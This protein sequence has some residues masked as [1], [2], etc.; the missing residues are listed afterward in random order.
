M[1]L[2]LDD[3][4]AAIA[5]APGAAGL[6]VVR[7][8]GRD[9]LAVADRVFR[10]RS[11]LESVAS[12]TLHH[13]W[14]MDGE[15]RVDEI[16][17]AVF[18]APHSYTREDVVELSCHGGALPS[19]RVLTALL[20]AGAR[21]AGPGEFTLRAFLNG[22]LDLAQA[23]AVADVIAAATGAAHDLAL[24]QLAGALSRRLDGLSESLVDALAEVEARVDFAEDVGGVEVPEHVVNAIGDVASSLGDLLR[25]ADYARALREGVRVPLVGRPNVGKSSLFNALLGESRAIVTELPGTT[26]D[27]VSETIEVAGV[28]VTLS[29]TA[30]LR[31]TDEP[32]ERIGVALAEQALADSALVLWVIDGAAPLTPE[33]REIA[34]R[35][36]GKPLLV[37]LNQCDRG[38]AVAVEDVAALLDGA[39]R[40][41]VRVS[42]VRGDGLE[43]VRESLASLLG[44]ERSGEAPAVAN[45]RHAEALGRAQ[46]ALVRASDAARAGAP[47]EVV[48]IELR[49]A[50]AAIGEVTGKAIAED[51]LERIF[52]KFCVG[53]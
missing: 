18:R 26:R 21:L 2:V 15:N 32:V 17:A 50:I 39:P 51:L 53:K 42:A 34:A 1:S 40:R 43:V 45:P 5:T 33:D 3:T 9:A 41:I 20:S 52:G 47:G 35:V 12:H 48:A 22:R 38:A 46:V 37:A 4:I 44:A 27:R 13:G 30:G 29:D 25:G 19:R 16:I 10:G 24:A 31:N 11:S 28:P 14:V 8:S 7:L 49:D 6:A 36:A 23:E